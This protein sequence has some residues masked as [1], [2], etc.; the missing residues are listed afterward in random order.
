VKVKVLLVLL[1]LSGAS[2]SAQVF[3][4]RPASPGGLPT[5]SEVRRQHV[6][7]VDFDNGVFTTVGGAPY[8]C[9]AI[10][11][12]TAAYTTTIASRPGILAASSSAS[13]NSG[14]FCE[15]G[16]FDSFVV[17]GGEHFEIAWKP[18]R[19]TTAAFFAGLQDSVSITAAVDGAWLAMDANGVL[20]GVTS[21]N[22][23]T[24]TTASNFQLVL[25]TWYRGVVHVTSTSSVTFSLYSEADALLWTDTLATNIPSGDTRGT[26]AGFRVYHTGSSALELADIDWIYY[27]SGVLQR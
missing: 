17:A 12:G 4:V 11:S 27:S 2:V 25:G 26:G 7:Y 23:S 18:L 21:S 16:Q 22:S 5:V 20:T 3:P 19:F 13:A 1:A 14:Y 6:A 9:G 24:S 10:G 8:Q 15:V